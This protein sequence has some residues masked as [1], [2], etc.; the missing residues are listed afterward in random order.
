MFKECCV[1]IANAK[2]AQYENVKLFLGL[3][4]QAIGT[5]EGR[6]IHIP[7]QLK[8]K[9]R[10]TSHRLFSCVVCSLRSNS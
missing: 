9:A 1:H 5:I 7:R 6:Y 4:A 2:A 10:R 8:E 3:Q